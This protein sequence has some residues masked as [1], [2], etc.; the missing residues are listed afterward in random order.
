M[1]RYQL[2]RRCS[3]MAIRTSLIFTMILSLLLTAQALPAARPL[4]KS[5]PV[6][7]VETP[8]VNGCC[9]SKACCEGSQQQQ[10]PQSP[11]PL[12]PRPEL[13]LA[14]DSQVF[15]LLHALLPATRDFIILDE[16]SGGHSLPPLAASC[17]RLI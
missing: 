6:G 2:A 5:T 15:A 13:Q 1:T 14:V 11:T 16:V 8:C 17:I 12:V 7:C 10:A 9:S 3:A 4:V